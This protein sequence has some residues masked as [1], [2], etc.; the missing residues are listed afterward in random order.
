MPKVKVFSSPGT[1]RPSF[2]FSEHKRSCTVRR[3]TP[4]AMRLTQG[5]E[6]F[7]LSTEIAVYLG[8][9]TTVGTWKIIGTPNRSVS[10]SM[11]FSDLERRDASCPISTKSP[12]VSSC[13]L[14]N[15]YLIRRDNTNGEGLFRRQQRPRP[16]TT[17]CRPV[18][19]RT[20]FSCTVLQRRRL[21]ASAMAR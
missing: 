14:T 16:G 20:C 12:S 19:S 21:D 11:T 7:R 6:S 9:G 1:G 4:S 18:H 2:Q 5:Q 13:R 3:A 10:V 17:D 15:G 8:N